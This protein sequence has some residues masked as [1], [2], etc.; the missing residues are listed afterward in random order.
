VT[1]SYEIPASYRLKGRRKPA[2]PL[3]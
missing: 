3:F 1:A 2:L